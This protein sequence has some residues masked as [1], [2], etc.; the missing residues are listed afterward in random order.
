MRQIIHKRR[1]GNIV[2]DLQELD[3]VEMETGADGRVRVTLVFMEG[4][5]PELEATRP[6]KP[7]LPGNPRDGQIQGGGPRA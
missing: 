3:A 5:G 1:S 6:G 7:I 2:Y 4:T